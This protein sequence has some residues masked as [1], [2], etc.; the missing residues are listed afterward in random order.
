MDANLQS[1][2]S[3][4]IDSPNQSCVITG[5]T[6]NNEARII[7]IPERI[8]GNVVVAVEDHVFQSCSY[9]QH[10]VVYGDVELKGDKNSLFYVRTPNPG[11]TSVSP[12]MGTAVTI[13]G[14]NGT[15]PSVF[16]TNNR[17]TFRAIGGIS[18]FN[19][20]LN[21][22]L[23]D[24]AAISFHK[25]EG[26]DSY[27]VYQKKGNG[28]YKLRATLSHQN[29]TFSCSGLEYGQ[30]YTYKM[31]PVY[32]TGT[33]DENGNAQVIEGI[34]SQEISINVTLDTL[35]KVQKR[36]NKG[37]ILLSWQRDKDVDGYEIY[38][39][40]SGKDSKGAYKLVK[41]I[42]SNKVV[43]YSDKKLKRGKS[44]S[45]KIRSFKKLSKSKPKGKKVYSSFV[46][47]SAKVK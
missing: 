3:I 46:T 37:S 29:Q 28:K 27:H 32:L 24:R 4:R 11:D 30:V 25:V 18:A 44:Y 23:Y 5:Y 22:K 17:M 19:V 31:C 2:F 39:K 42:K 16:A 41:T 10:L 34:F 40:T 1:N 9:L 43:Q 15:K 8:Q 14:I 26:A 47:V 38:R 21:R 13:W 7:A 36:S 33:F 45:Y 6:G 35:K 20:K 12:L